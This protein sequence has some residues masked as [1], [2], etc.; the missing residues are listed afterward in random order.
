[1]GG[2]HKITIE[3]EE[4]SSG[5]GQK[6][7]NVLLALFV[8]VAFLSMM[9]TDDTAEEGD[10]ETSVN[11]MEPFGNGEWGCTVVL[12]VKAVRDL[13]RTE[14]VVRAFRGDE[15]LDESDRLKVHDLDEGEK[16]YEEFRLD[17]PC[18]EIER[19]EIQFVHGDGC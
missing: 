8:V 13:R 12:E 11:S 18:S 3:T 19:H 7:F 17:V 5:L 10:Y 14:M 15:F 4:P 6:V 1:M 2:R 16:S 9:A